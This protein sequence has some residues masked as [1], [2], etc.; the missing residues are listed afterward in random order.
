VIGASFS[1]ASYRN[2][3]IIMTSNLGA[4]FLNEADNSGPVLPGT[5]ELVMGAIRAHL[6]PE[7]IN[8]IDDIVIFVSFTQ[9]YP[10]QIYSLCV[11]SAHSLRKTSPQSSTSDSKRSRK[12]LQTGK[13]TS[14]L[15]LE[16]NNISPALATLPYT[17]LVL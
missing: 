3:V 6:P 2:C 1:D 10:F 7:F 4:A 9:L 15:I 5:K 17:A 16:Q 11:N 8:R 12:D 13:F 14:N